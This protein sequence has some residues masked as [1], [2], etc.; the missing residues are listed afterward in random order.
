MPDEDLDGIVDI[1]YSIPYGLHGVVDH[2]PLTAKP[3]PPVK[4]DC[5]EDFLRTLCVLVGNGSNENPFLIEN[6]RINGSGYGY[7]IYIGNTSMHFLVQNCTLVYG[8]DMG[9]IILYNVRNGNLSGNTIRACENGIYLLF[10]TSN[11]IERNKVNCSAVGLRLYLSD[12]NRIERNSFSENLYGVYL[13]LGRE[14]TIRANAIGENAEMGVALYSAIT[15]TISEN[16]ISHNGQGIYM[17]YSCQNVVDRNSFIE[18]MGYGAYLDFGSKSNIIKN[19]IFM[20][21]N[22]GGLQH[23][24]VENANSWV[25]TN[26]WL[27][28]T[29]TGVNETG[30]FVFAVLIVIL[31]LAWRRKFE[32]NL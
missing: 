8:N 2:F 32:S 17:Y 30:N 4:I 5:D 10:S 24:D 18:N 16:N 7:C 25:E 12:A 14:N 6:L 31:V 26:R 23:Y 13:W 19:N 20:G 22:K 29:V 28:N 3:W 11:Q 15:N 1:P 27:A 21:N 9:G